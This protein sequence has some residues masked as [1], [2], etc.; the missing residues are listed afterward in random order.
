MAK[1]EDFGVKIT[2]YCKNQEKWGL[3]F[4]TANKSG[5]LCLLRESLEIG[6]KFGRL[7]AKSGEL[8]GM[9]NDYAC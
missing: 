3:N 9:V 5:V 7:P 8:T 1:S 2:D 4:Q 6:L